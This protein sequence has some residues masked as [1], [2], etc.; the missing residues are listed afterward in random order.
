MTIGRLAWII[1]AAILVMAINVGVSFLYVAI[2]SHLINR[3][4]DGQY[5]QEYAKKVAP[6]SG[7]AAGIPLMFLMCWWVGSWWDAGFAVKAA[8]L[9]WLVYAVIDVLVLIGAGMSKRVPTR[10]VVLTTIALIAKLAAS[11]LGGVVSSRQV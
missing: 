2:Y 9:V 5:Y 4:H 7:I 1:G 11:Y 10:L 8:I 3:G 6:Y